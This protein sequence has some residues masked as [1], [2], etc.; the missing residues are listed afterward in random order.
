MKPRMNTDEHRFFSLFFLVL[1]FSVNSAAQQTS[2]GGVYEVG[3]G[4]TDEK[5]LVAYF[6]RFGYRA[7]FIGTAVAVM[8][9]LSLVTWLRANTL[10]SVTA[11]A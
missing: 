3:I 11:Q 6:E 7:D 10:R 1:I 8:C 2:I 4:A 5:P 9:A